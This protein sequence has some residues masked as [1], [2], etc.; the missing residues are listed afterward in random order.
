MEFFFAA[1]NI[2]TS[3]LL[4]ADIRGHVS[5]HERCF[6]LVGNLIIASF[7]ATESTQNTFSFIFSIVQYSTEKLV[8]DW[9]RTR[10]IGGEGNDADH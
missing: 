7:D 4:T 5:K 2:E 8:A 10:I 6:G 1:K 9:I 3:E